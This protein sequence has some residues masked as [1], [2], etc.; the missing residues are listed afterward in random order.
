MQYLVIFTPKEEFETAGMPADY[1]VRQLEE[2]AQ[3]RVLYAQGVLR[4]SWELDTKRHGA[5][6]LFEASS[7]EHLQ[8]MLDSFP[9][10]KNDYVDYQIFPLKPDPAY[11]Q[12]LSHTDSQ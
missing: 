1:A 10:V 3:G 4:Q 12:G 8:E 6:C 11:T 5:A 2:L 7:T 9:H